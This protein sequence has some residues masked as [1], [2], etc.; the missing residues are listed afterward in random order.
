MYFLVQYDRSRGALLSLRSFDS[1]QRTRAHEER[2]RTEL[3]HH[4]HHSDV[5]VVLLEADD[6]T[7]LRIT[8]KRYF[9]SLESLAKL[10]SG[11]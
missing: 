10:A 4:R 2:L 8:H 1:D 7:A 5:E 6:E 11:E 3:G 9:E